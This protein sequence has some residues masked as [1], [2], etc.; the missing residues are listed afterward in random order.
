M[1]LAAKIVGAILGLIAAVMVFPYLDAYVWALVAL[2]GAV[3]VGVLVY[4]GVVKLIAALL[5]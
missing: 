3:A 4:I 1:E 2:A 5:R